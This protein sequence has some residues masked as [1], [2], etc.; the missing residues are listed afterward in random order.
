MRPVIS[1]AS[2][3]D[4]ISCS[5]PDSLLSGRFGPGYLTGFFGCWNIYLHSGSTSLIHKCWSK[6]AARSDISELD[7]SISVSNFILLFLI[8]IVSS[9]SSITSLKSMVTDIGGEDVWTTSS[10]WEWMGSVTVDGGDDRMET[11]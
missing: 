2:A 11:F 10:K 9:M 6:D 7:D 3:L 8:V 5:Y 4:K 1:A